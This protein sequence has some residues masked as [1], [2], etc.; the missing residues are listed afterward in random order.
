MSH[1]Y[2]NKYNYNADLISKNNNFDLLRLFAASE[3]L[4]QHSIA[5]LEI[6][7]FHLVENILSYFPGVLIF[8]TIS[9]F[10]IFSSLDRNRDFKK[11]F[12]NRALRIFPALWVCFFLTFILL[13]FFDVIRYTNIFDFVIVK[14]IFGQVTFFQFW[15]PDILRGW[16]VGTP[17]GSLWTIPV[18]IQFYI[19]LPVITLVFKKIKL[20]FKFLF[21]IILS[22]PFN[23]YISGFN[24]SSETL[25]IKLLTV[26]IFP[27]LFSFLTGSVIYLYWNKIRNLL[28]GFFPLSFWIIFFI[29]FNYSF[30]LKPVNNPVNLQLISNLL[31]SILT[32]SF[33]FSLPNFSKF[34]KGN[35]ISY[36]IYIY[37]MLVIN[38]F[39]SIGFIGNVKFLV[40]TFIFTFIISSISW[41]F[42]EKKM[43]AIKNKFY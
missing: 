6:G 38:T 30:A 11:Y 10:L 1:V 41:F 17:N 23:I 8:F 24:V 22:I 2:S 31:L 29:I 3:V 26:S 9:G 15:T 37:H 35:D 7:G 4:F 20:I 27:Y 43:L 13:I 42:V 18:E 28:I 25:L 36:G 21:F 14:W 33:A 40:L 5:H 16:G 32:I 39:I 12:I 34:L 19:L